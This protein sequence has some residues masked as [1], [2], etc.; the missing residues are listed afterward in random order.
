MN[1]SEIREG[2]YP[3]EGVYWYLPPRMKE[4][5]CS[6]G[7]NHYSEIQNCPILNWPTE[8][9]WTGCL[10]ISDAWFGVSPPPHHQTFFKLATE[11]HR[12][13]LT[14]TAYP[15]WFPHCLMAY[16]LFLSISS[17]NLSFQQQKHFPV[18]SDVPC[19][20][21]STFPFLLS[22][23]SERFL[24]LCEVFPSTVTKAGT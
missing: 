5:N 11:D 1:Y 23:Q 15:Q 16:I 22:L 13:T 18:F 9:C 19:C 12:I 10:F 24:P 14:V 21:I 17:L 6:A 2:D 20:F 3:V 7:Q 4:T 8:K